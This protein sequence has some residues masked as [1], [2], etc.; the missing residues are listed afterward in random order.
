MSSKSPLSIRPI[1][2]KLNPGPLGSRLLPNGCCGQ[3]S[4]N[5]RKVLESRACYRDWGITCCAYL[6]SRRSNSGSASSGARY[7]FSALGDGR[8][9]DMGVGFLIRHATPS[10]TFS[11]RVKTPQTPKVFALACIHPYI[12]ASQIGFRPCTFTIP[13]PSTPAQEN[14]MQTNT[15]F[16]SPVRTGVAVAVISFN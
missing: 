8:S 1:V 10:P 16:L 13:I 15:S 2:D 9:V 3:C 12:S 7:L 4:E 6:V 5:K 11:R 14:L